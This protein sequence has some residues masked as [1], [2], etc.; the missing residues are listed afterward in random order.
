LGVAGPSADTNVQVNI[1]GKGNLG[2][3]IQGTGAAGN[4]T[5]GYVGE[6]ISSVIG[7]GSAVSLTTATAK[8]L[9]SIS[10][11][12]GDWD[13]MGNVT[14]LG[15]S[16]ILTTAQA[17]C[18]LSSATRP[19]GSLYAGIVSTAVLASSVGVVAP[20]FRVNVSTTTL[21]YVSAQAVFATGT[22]TM[23]GGIY[24]RRVR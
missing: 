9:T 12:A 20:F 13:V 21:V 1:T 22:T 19:D 6:V 24:A 23:S 17:W 11:T 3:A 18:S 10:L 14:I 2:A 5:A 4:A 7:T 8:D 16:T 15:S